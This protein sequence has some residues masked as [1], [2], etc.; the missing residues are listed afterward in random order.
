MAM[1]VWEGRVEGG[2]DWLRGDDATRTPA[3]QELSAFAHVC[4]RV[5]ST[6]QRSAKPPIAALRSALPLPLDHVL[7]LCFYRA[8]SRLE[9]RDLLL[10]TSKK[11]LLA[12]ANHPG[13]FVCTDYTLPTR[14]SGTCR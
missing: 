9:A 12:W 8:K 14:V 7:G 5:R 10:L 6:Y 11:L 13:K 1:I 4:Y 3:H 2:E